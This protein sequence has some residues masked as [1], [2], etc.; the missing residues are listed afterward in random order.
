MRMGELIA[1]KP[2]DLNF[3]GNFIEIRR[4]CVR[5]IIST[6]ESG[7]IRRVDMSS[8]LRRVL[9][10]FLTSRKQEA[11]RKG[12]GQPPEWLFYN[13]AGYREPTNPRSTSW[14]IRLH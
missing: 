5:G 2:G 10:Y 9:K 12:W 1:L 4:I 8:E 14:T 7:K 6:P 11:L 3:N 13:S